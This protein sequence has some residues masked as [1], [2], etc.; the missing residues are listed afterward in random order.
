MRSEIFYRVVSS[1]LFIPVLIFIAW[2]GGIYYLCLIELGIWLG[3]YEFFKILEIRGLKPYTFLGI[4]AALVLGW[5]A[6]FASHI[7]TFLTLT[8]L[9]FVVSISELYR[10]TLDRAIFHIS[11]TLFGVFYVGWLMSHLI[12]LRQIPAFLHYGDIMSNLRNLKLSYFFP[13]LIFTT[14][15]DKGTVY[16]LIPFVLAW[17]NDTGAYLIGRKYGKHKVFKRVSPGKSWEGVIGGGLCGTI[18]IFLLKYSGCADWLSV[19]DCIFLSLLGGCAAPAGDFIES[20]LK[21]DAK[22]RHAG[23]TIPGHGGMLDRFDSVLFIAPL[24]YYY[25]R[26]FVTS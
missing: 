4:T 19:I 22:V 6:Y 17:G 2:N 23:T 26:F 20:L 14:G 18:G 13:Y 15:Y 10:R 25:L 5:N 3:A 21:R 12:L 7:F 1:V 8:V 24:V 9:F 16:T 11:A